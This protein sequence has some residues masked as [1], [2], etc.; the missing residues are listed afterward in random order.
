[1]G[2]TSD[3][4]LL[5]SLVRVNTISSPPQNRNPLV[6][7]L[8]LIVTISVPHLFL[9]MHHSDNDLASCI[10]SQEWIFVKQS[11]Q[12]KKK[13]GKVACRPKLNQ[14]NPRNREVSVFIELRSIQQFLCH[15]TTSVLLL[16]CMILQG[17]RSQ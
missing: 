14:Q 6:C 2:T 1:M 3:L 16:S 13:K 10:K 9:S 12:D 17:E 7:V 4:L 11:F 15:L 8:N 5:V